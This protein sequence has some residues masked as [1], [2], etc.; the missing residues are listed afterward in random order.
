MVSF[1]WERIQLLH[2][3]ENVCQPGHDLTQTM[4]VFYFSFKREGYRKRF[5]TNIFVFRFS[6]SQYTFP[7]DIII[8]VLQ[9]ELII[10]LSSQHELILLTKEKN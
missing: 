4:S 5:V 3:L 2:L 7:V 9:T 6:P 10:F 8:I 1:S